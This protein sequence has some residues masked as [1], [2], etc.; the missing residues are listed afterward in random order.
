MRVPVNPSDKIVGTGT[1][2]EVKIVGTGYGTVTG[3]VEIG[4]STTGVHAQL[5]PTQVGLMVV[6]KSSDKSIVTGPIA[7]I[8]VTT[9]T[10][11]GA[12][13]VTATPSTPQKPG[14]DPT[15]RFSSGFGLAK[16]VIATASDAKKAKLFIVK[17]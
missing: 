12:L 5:V 10:L 13:S 14:Q 6:V 7:G 11:T 15:C 17:W 16:A 4:S 1:P 9:D 8:K 3:M 2:S